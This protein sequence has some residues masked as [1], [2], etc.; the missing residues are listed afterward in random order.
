MKCKFYVNHGIKQSFLDVSNIS[1]EFMLNFAESNI[2]PL[3]KK[4]TK[5]YLLKQ[6]PS[7]SNPFYCSL[8]NCCSTF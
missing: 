6:I 2:I 8:R 5:T 7:W 1:S 4:I 3:V